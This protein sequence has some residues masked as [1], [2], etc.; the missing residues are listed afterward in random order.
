MFSGSLP[1]SRLLSGNRRRERGPAC[2]R[3]LGQSLTG[4]DRA[5]REDTGKIER[6]RAPRSL[7]VSLLLQFASA[8][9][10][11]AALASAQR[12]QLDSRLATLSAGGDVHI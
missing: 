10:A 7:L 6:M 2:Q 8:T 12:A 11:D 1:R 4:V 9:Q 5:R 3:S